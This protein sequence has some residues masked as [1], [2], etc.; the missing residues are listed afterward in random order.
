CCRKTNPI[1]SGRVR[2][3]SFIRRAFS[4][5]REVT[6]MAKKQI[7]FATEEALERRIVS[8]FLHYN[9]DPGKRKMRCWREIV[10]YY[11]SK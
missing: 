1:V 5:K 10:A 9:D 6:R 11:E 3:S 2:F 7:Q 4:P 8:M